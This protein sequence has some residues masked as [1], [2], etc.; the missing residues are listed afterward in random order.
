MWQVLDSIRQIYRSDSVAFFDGVYRHV[1]WQVRRVL[2]RFPC[3]L[4]ISRSRLLVERPTGVAALVNAMGMYDLHNMSLI[5][6]VLKGRAKTFVDIGANIG[7]YTLIASEIGAARVV[8]IE[9]HPK[10]FG[11]LQR[12]VE[13]NQRRNVACLNVAVSDRDG[14]VL[15]TD[16]AGLSINRIVE[17]EGQGQSCLAVP[18]RT[19]DSICRDLA[20][21]PSVVKIDVEGHEAVALRGFGRSLSRAGIVLVEGGE[22]A[23]ICATLRSAGFRGP[24]YFHADKKAFSPSTQRRPEDPVY[25]SEAGIEWLESVGIVGG[26]RNGIP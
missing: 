11:M 23:V 4:R 24:L 5:Q 3:E 17:S 18:C 1:Q 6:T 20:L 9:P 2:D 22:Q 8:S 15:L 13:L 16:R 25:L 19:M 12:N 26:S 7:T 10:T 14:Q 21:E